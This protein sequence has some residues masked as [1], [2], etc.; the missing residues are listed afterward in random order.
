MTESIQNYLSGTNAFYHQKD[1]QSVTKKELA[2]LKPLIPIYH[3][4]IENRVWRLTKDIFSIIIF[5]IGI[6]RAI[7]AIAGKVIV[8]A[9]LSSEHQIVQLGTELNL[10][11]TWKF[12]RLAVEVDG[13]IIDCM[14][15]GK[16]STFRNN[17]WLLK[18]NG[19]G[20]RYESLLYNQNFKQILS[21]TNSNALIFNYPGVESSTGFP[22]Q[23]ALTKAY[24]AMLKFLE[25]EIGAKEIIGYGHSLGGGVQGEALRSHPLR[26]DVKYVFVKRQTFSDI[27][28]VAS[29]MVAKSAGIFI[30]LFG[31]NLGSVESSK[32]LK[33]PE[34][35]MQKVEGEKYIKL[36][37]N[38]GV[39]KHDG[40]IPAEASLAKKLLDESSYDENKYFMGIPEFH[41]QLLS[42]PEIL[43]ARIEKMFQ[44]S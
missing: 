34:I 42:R 4:T 22:T 8:P 19:N 35:I 11:G 38:H 15:M 27:P 20:E 17:R 44:K 37:K 24:R 1:Y 3:C 30:K 6:Y 13:N 28:T 25:D 33:V 36:K 29:H 9:S 21:K 10:Q 26:K 43:T 39:I 23:K 7:H 5:P 18:S 14:I 31:W 32:N 16:P 40:V 2:S 41:N 12:K